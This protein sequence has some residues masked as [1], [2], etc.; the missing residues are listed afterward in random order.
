MDKRTWIF[1]AL[2]LGVAVIL[3]ALVSPFASSAPD[4]LD[5]F[6]EDYQFTQKA[7]GQDVWTRAPMADYRVAPVKSVGLST[8][9]AGALGTL[10]VFAAAFGVG[11]LVRRRKTDPAGAASP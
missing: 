4:G 8:G 6:A 5:T 2:A 9:L 10:V 3:G 7:E 1:I 11:L